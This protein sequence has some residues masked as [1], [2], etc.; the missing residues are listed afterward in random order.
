MRGT[1]RWL[2]PREGGRSPIPGTRYVAIAWL[3]RD[4]PTEDWSIVINGIAA[5]E[6]RPPIMRFNGDA[7]QLPAF[8]TR[9]AQ[10]PRP[11]YRLT[12]TQLGGTD[13]STMITRPATSDVVDLVLAALVAGG[14]AIIPDILTATETS[15]VLDALRN[16]PSENIF[17]D[18]V[19][20][21]T[22]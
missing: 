9:G 2:R 6:G 3:E 15:E 18:L 22:S 16:I 21:A 5:A 10:T 1:R 4:A 20:D 19:G 14:V 8:L 7:T 17:G 12:H 11:T 13:M